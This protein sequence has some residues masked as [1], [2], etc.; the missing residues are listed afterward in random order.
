MDILLVLASI[1]TPMDLTMDICIA[2]I[3]TSGWA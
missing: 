3:L 1:I 2:I